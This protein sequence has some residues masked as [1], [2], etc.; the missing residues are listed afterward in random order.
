VPRRYDEK[1]PSVKG[2]N[3]AQVKAFCQRNDA[4]IHYLQRA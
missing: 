1:V 4:S 3:L 2:G